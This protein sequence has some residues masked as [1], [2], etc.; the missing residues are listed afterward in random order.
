MP[1]RT[2]DKASWEG[3]LGGDGVA[4]GEDELSMAVTCES[5][6]TCGDSSS[7]LEAVEV[8]VVDEVEGALRWPNTSVVCSSLSP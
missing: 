5:H 8:A 1:P 7:T 2:P 3:T 6:L 4:V